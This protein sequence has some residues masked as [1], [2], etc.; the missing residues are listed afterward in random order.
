M[1]QCPTE[2]EL[3]SRLARRLPKTWRS[4][5]D[6]NLRGLCKRLSGVELMQA[7][8]PEQNKILGITMGC[9]AG[10]GP[11]VI[12]KAFSRRPEWV[13]NPS[14][15]VIGDMAVLR[16]ASSAM[17]VDF[18]LVPWTPGM[19]PASGSINV[20]EAT[21]LDPDAVPWS[22]PN[23]ES[24]M[25][26]YQYVVKGIELCKKGVLSG[27]ATAPISKT[28]LRMADVRYPG[29]TEILA[30]MTG[31]VSY[32]MMMAGSRLKVILVTIHC[33]L[34]DVPG[35]ISREQIVE[36]IRLAS[37]ALSRDLGLE[38]AKIAVAGLNPHAGEGGIMGDEE[39]LIIA[40][41]VEQARKLGMDVSGPFPPDTVFYNAA[42][43]AFDAVIC[44]Y[45]DQGLIPFKLLHFRDG[46]NVTLGLPFVRTSVDH[47]TAYDIAGKNI[48]HSESM[49]AAVDLAVKM[50]RNRSHQAVGRK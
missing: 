11:E 6:G 49:E 12:L 1:R 45:H 14:A 7:K 28:G 27:L 17:G 10:V 42:Q 46:V 30:D 35:K 19:E 31:T 9:P 48:A 41:A 36:K 37:Q 32:A 4:L 33:A 24:G 22:G 5:S 26:S 40:P 20:F 25:A 2:S 3:F 18:P 47:G 43:G 50:I 15:V 13:L 44:Q 39:E 21:G 34:K 16:R 23:R 38:S 29:H 8:M